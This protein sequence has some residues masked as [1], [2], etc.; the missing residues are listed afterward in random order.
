[1]AFL[2]FSRGHS[3]E[4]L[5]QLQKCMHK[6]TSL[7][8]VPAEHKQTQVN[9]ASVE[10]VLSLTTAELFYPVHRVPSLRRGLAQG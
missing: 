9:F 2:F 10:W 3:L 5:T 6:G 1:M 4:M 8:A 7:Y